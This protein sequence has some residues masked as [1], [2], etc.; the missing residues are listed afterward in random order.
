MVGEDL[1]EQVATA[2]R[3]GKAVNVVRVATDNGWINRSLKPIGEIEQTVEMISRQWIAIVTQ[4]GDPELEASKVVSAI[5]FI[6]KTIEASQRDF[7]E[8][9]SPAI[10]VIF[11]VG[12]ASAWPDWDHGRVTKYFI[13][14]QRL[15]IEVAV[16][17]NI[18]N[19]AAVIDYLIEEL[20]GANALAFEFYRQK[21]IKFPLAE[22]EKVIAGIKA[23]SPLGWDNSME[24]SK[25]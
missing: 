18:A 9:S 17:K 13:E 3:D 7:V 4:L 20:H 22:A 2:A 16:P 21:G 15:L 6:K 14:Q 12:G 8:G 5:N 10:K 1:V 25:N 11:C 19:S 23:A 24:N